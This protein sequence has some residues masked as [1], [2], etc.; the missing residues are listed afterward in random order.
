M[1]FRYG[2][3]PRLISLVSLIGYALMF[4]SSIAGWFDL[5]NI[6]PGG[7]GQL[8][9]LPVSVFEIILLPFWLLFRGFK[10]AEAPERRVRSADFLTKYTEKGQDQNLT[11][12]FAIFFF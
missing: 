1:L 7:S 9:F 8:L 12:I 5:V 2:L 3:V 6:S 10:T 11:H 4:L